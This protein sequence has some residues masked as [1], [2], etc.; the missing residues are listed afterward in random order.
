MGAF[1]CDWKLYLNPL[2]FLFIAKMRAIHQGQLPDQL[3]HLFPLQH[4]YYLV[5]AAHSSF[6]HAEPIV[7]LTL[8]PTCHNLLDTS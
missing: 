6:V 2:S 4:Y 7:S 5:T 1:V 3:V 8:L